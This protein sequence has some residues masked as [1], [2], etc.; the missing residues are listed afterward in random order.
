MIPAVLVL[1]GLFL[2]GVPQ[3]GR[4]PAADDN[5]REFLKMRTLLLDD[6]SAARPTAQP[7]ARPLQASWRTTTPSRASRTM[8][9][10]GGPGV[11]Q[12]RHPR[13]IRHCEELGADCY[14]FLIWHQK[15]D[16]EASRLSWRPPRRAPNSPPAASLSG[17]TSSPVRKPVDEIRALRPGLRRLDGKHRPVLGVP[18][19]GRGGLHRRFRWSPITGRLHRESL[20]RC[21]RPPT[22]TIP[23]WRRDRHVLG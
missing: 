6:R 19:I 18:S 12:G 15:T 22:A 13:L 5:E 4:V 1:G 2:R 14:H 3:Q 8:T 20:K 21:G 16:R 11:G 17:F 9:P 7:G 10:P 23:G